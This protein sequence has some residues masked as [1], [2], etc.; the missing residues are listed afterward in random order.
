M[1]TLRIAVKWGW[2][3]AL[4]AVV[5]VLASLYK[6]PVAAVAPILVVL[7]ATGLVA[8]VNS[9]EEKKL[10]RASMR[11][12]QLAEHFD[13]RF[14]GSSVVSIFAIIDSLFNV[15]DPKLWQWAQ[16]CD[17]SQR[18]FNTWYDSF[19]S[20]VESDFRTTRFDIYLH[21]YL[22]EMWLV[23]SHYFE[24]VEQFYEVAKRSRLPAG[25]VDQYNSFVREYNA[26][27]ESFR[28][29]LGELRSI[30]KIEIEPPSVKLAS[31]LAARAK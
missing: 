10:E 15:E 24:F 4:I 1:S 21:T 28:D 23:N 30:A 13:R 18:I 26:F 16:A 25:T 7:L 3:P 31:E 27:V 8:V 11:L 6:W 12:K 5:A 19:L 9:S 29:S 20:R 2:C 14:M 22:N 17:M